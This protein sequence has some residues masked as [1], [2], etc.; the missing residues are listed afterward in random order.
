MAEGEQ[1]VVGRR[2]LKKM[3]GVMIGVEE[4]A[5]WGLLVAAAVVVLGIGPSETGRAVAVETTAVVEVE[6]VEGAVMGF[7]YNSQKMG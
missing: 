4:V 6:T 3:I 2:E 7:D 5:T 1:E